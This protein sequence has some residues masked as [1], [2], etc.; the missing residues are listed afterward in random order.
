[1]VSKVVKAPMPI[2]IISLNGNERWAK[3]VY[4]DLVINLVNFHKKTEQLMLGFF[5]NG[6]F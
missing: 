6:R 1:M 2:F 3:S 4:R 5:M